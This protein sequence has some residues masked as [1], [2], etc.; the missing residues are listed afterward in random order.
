[1]N[2]IERSYHEATEQWKA[3]F[4]AGIRYH[5]ARC[6]SLIRDTGADDLSRHEARCPACIEGWS[7]FDRTEGEERELDDPRSGQ[8]TV[9]NRE[10]K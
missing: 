3:G 7:I 9:I 1:M 4:R 6:G 5:R 2:E 8:A 10:R